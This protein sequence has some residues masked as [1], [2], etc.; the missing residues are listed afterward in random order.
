MPRV[1][2]FRSKPQMP[3]FRLGPLLIVA[4][5]CVAAIGLLAL[6]VVEPRPPVKHFEVPVPSERFAR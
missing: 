3:T 1:R 6:A 5:L 4:V 2:L